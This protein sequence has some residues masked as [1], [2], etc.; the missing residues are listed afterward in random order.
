MINEN[1]YIAHLKQVLE[2]LYPNC[3]Y[4]KAQLLTSNNKVRL[5]MDDFVM[6]NYGSYYKNQITQL[7]KEKN[8]LYEFVINKSGII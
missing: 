1:R 7:V 8:Q 4:T 5:A 6:S 2:E 3:D